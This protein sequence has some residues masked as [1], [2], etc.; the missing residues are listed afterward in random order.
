MQ[1][2]IVT[3]DDHVH[4]TKLV[5]LTL[6]KSGF[7]VESYS[8]G[9]NAWNAIQDNPPSLLVTDFEMP[10]MDGMELCRKLKS[11]PDIDLP[12]IFLTARAFDLSPAQLQR[13]LGVTAV[14]HKPFSP[15]QLR[16]LVHGILVH[17]RTEEQS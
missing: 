8:D 6:R 17:E 2:R 7:E 15:K 3:C 13:D 9:L 16:E 10:H 5:E 14:L 11:S 4:I 12:I 1:Q